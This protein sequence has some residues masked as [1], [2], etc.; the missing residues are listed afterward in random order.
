M[1]N[2]CPKPPPTSW[3][4][5]RTRCDGT[6]VTREIACLASCGFC[7][8]IHACSSPAV[9]SYSTTIPRVSI[10]TGVVALLAEGALHHRAPVAVEQGLQ[11]GRDREL[12][13][14][15]EVRAELGM[16]ERS[17]FV[18]R[19]L[20]VD[21]RGLDLDVDLDELGRV[22]GDVAALGDDQHDRLADEPHVAVGERAQRRARHPQ[23]HRRLHVAGV[24]IEIGRG[25]HG[26]HTVDG[27]GLG[28]VD[29]HDAPAPRRC[30]RTCSATCP[31][32]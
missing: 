13:L 2:F 31:G 15:A 21:D 30:A 16:H 9:G 25:E 1:K 20:D 5:T 8:L 27:A 24:R 19:V 17:A 4:S 22:L 28:D 26:D 11:L 6:P 3:P 12:H 29:A 10:G 23:Q 18:E 14:G 7:V 32:A